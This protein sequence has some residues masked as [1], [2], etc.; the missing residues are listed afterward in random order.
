MDDHK[1]MKIISDIMWCAGFCEEAGF[2][3][4]RDKLVNCKEE[5]KSEFSYNKLKKDV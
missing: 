5:L 1:L 4:V 2:T 3:N